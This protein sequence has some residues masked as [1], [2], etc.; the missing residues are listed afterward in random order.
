MILRNSCYLL[1]VML[2]SVCVCFVH[3]VTNTEHCWNIS[4]KMTW[5]LRFALEYFNPTKHGKRT[6][7]QNRWRIVH[8]CWNWAGQRSR[9]CFC[10][11]LEIFVIEKDVNI[12]ISEKW[13]LWVV[14]QWSRLW[15]GVSS[16][17]SRDVRWGQLKDFSPHTKFG[18]LLCGNKSIK[19]KNQI[20]YLKV[21][22]P[23]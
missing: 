6:N 9:G 21:G 12:M 10:S 17:S 14:S 23:I 4:G 15:R 8:N 11:C 18:L 1:S 19:Q 7:V 20:F 3:T 22:L 5:E 13:E 16:D 2:L